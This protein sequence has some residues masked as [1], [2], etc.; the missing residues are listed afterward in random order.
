M[1]FFGA[2]PL[3][4]AG[5]CWWNRWTGVAGSHAGLEVRVEQFEIRLRLLPCASCAQHVG[6]V[7]MLCS[8]YQ[9]HLYGQRYVVSLV[10][11]C[12][13]R[14]G[15]CSNLQGTEP[16]LRGLCSS[17]LREGCDFRG[18]ALRLQSTFHSFGVVHKQIDTDR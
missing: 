1:R 5:V 15:S 8:K 10:V 12:W 13:S 14:V 3:H 9:G 2:D 16:W 18:L 11:S 17:S 4:P 6:R 7:R